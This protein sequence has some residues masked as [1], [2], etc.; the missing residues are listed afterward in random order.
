MDK[1]KGR[2]AHDVNSKAIKFESSEPC[3]SSCLREVR[4]EG[5]IAVAVENTRES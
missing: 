5:V 3:C 2:Y 4:K 1:Y